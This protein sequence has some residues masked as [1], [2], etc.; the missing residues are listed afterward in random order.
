VIVGIERDPL[1]SLVKV[2]IN[3]TWMVWSISNFISRTITFEVLS[4]T[5]CLL[6]DASIE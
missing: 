4:L 2:S 3:E 6:V 5:S 1:F